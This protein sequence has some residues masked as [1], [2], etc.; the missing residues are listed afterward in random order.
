MASWRISRRKPHPEGRSMS[1]PCRN[2]ERSAVIA[3]LVPIALIAVFAVAANNAGAQQDAAPSA[4]RGPNEVSVTGLFPNGGA[5]PPRPPDAI[6]GRFE[7][8]KLAIADG[9]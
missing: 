1:S 8:N 9:E 3:R 2:P 6:G 7:E 4:G 5:P